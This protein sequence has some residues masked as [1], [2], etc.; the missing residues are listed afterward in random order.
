MLTRHWRG[1][2]EEN[3]NWIIEDNGF[4]NGDI[5]L[6]T[7]KK[8]GKTYKIWNDVFWETK[9]YE[10]FPKKSI[11]HG[12]LENAAKIKKELDF[13]PGS[14]CD[15]DRFSYSYIFENYSDFVLTKNIVFT[16][17]NELMK[18]KDILK[19]ITKETYKIFARPDSPLKEFS[20]RVLDSENLTPAHFDYGFYHSNMDLKIVLS[21]YKIIEK[22]FRFVCVNKRIITG[23]E[24]IADGR[25]GITST[26]NEE[27]WM[28]AQKIADVNKQ[29][30]FAYII[31]VCES[32]GKL[33]L[34]EMNPFSGADLYCCDAEKII[35]EIEKA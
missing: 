17:I 34:V 14:L 30:D 16:T 25:K 15:E 12:S 20:G 9:E 29:K 3:M 7:L 2:V 28:F 5:L 8:L 4:A 13:V 10:S 33:F 11:F 22:E 23:C 19:S 21:E 26:I 6:P 31:D 24:Y 27:A 18:N 32:N 1:K 35:N